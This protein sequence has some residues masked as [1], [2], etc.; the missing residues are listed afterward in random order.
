MENAPKEDGGKL[1]LA[2]QNGK[3]LSREESILE[4]DDVGSKHPKVFK[5]VQAKEKCYGKQ[6]I[7]TR[8]ITKKKTFSCTIPVS[9]CNDQDIESTEQAGQLRL[10][11]NDDNL[12][13]RAEQEDSCILESEN[14]NEDGER[15]TRIKSRAEFSTGEMAV[16]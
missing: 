6:F 5:R 7:K 2:C 14:E 16:S 9:P 15:F 4:K 13:F 10:P 3:L 11:E 1:I 8:S 12:Q